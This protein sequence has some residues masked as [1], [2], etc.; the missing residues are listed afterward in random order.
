VLNNL[1]NATVRRIA[2]QNPEGETTEIGTD[3]DTENEKE[4][5]TKEEENEKKLKRAGNQGLTVTERDRRE[6]S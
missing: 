3:N 1:G 4:T 2:C 6:N 5:G